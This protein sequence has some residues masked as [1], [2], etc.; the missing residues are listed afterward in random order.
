MPNMQTVSF[1]TP[2]RS[3][4][5]PFASEDE[6]AR[7]RAMAKALMEAAQQNTDIRAPSQ[8]LNLIAQSA[9]SGALLRRSGQQADQRQQALAQALGGALGANGGQVDPQSLAT[10]MALNPELGAQL[11]QRQQDMERQAAQDAAAAEQRQYERSRPIEVGGNLVDP[12]TYQPVYQAPQKPQAQPADVQEYEYA[13]SQGYKGS[14]TDFQTEMRRA[15]AT[16]VNVG[17]DG[18]MGQV[19]PGTVAVPDPTQPSG[20]RLVP[21]G[22]S[23]A[24]RDAQADAN[25]ATARTE[26]RTTTADIVIEDITRGLDLA[27]RGWGT[28]GFAGGLLQ[29]VPGTPAHDLSR[30]L[31]TIKANVGFDQ[32]QQMRESS[33]TG[34]ALGPVSDAENRLLQSVLGSVEQSQTKEQFDFNMNRL[35]NVFL[36]IVHGPSGP[37]PVRD[38]PQSADP[39]SQPAAPAAPGGV[40]DWTPDGGLRPAQ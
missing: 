4:P 17:P 7:Q 22:G 9:L 10:V 19:P 18:K 23:P 1:D 27:E 3:A 35:R 6:I 21:M 8:G 16:S 20:F 11:V 25:A 36:G 37:A 15:G 39:V 30:L 40:F 28:T 32:L 12:N 2:Q 33:P 34:G 13:R 24:E 38:R 29:S 5:P 31:E 26:R 14:F